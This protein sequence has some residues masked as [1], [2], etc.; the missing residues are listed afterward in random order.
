MGTTDRSG[1]TNGAWHESDRNRTGVDYPAPLRRAQKGDYYRAIFDATAVASIVLSPDGIVQSWNLG[2]EKLFG[3]SED[4]VINRSV[5]FLTAPQHLGLGARNPETG[6]PHDQS[7][8]WNTIKCR[9]DGSLVDVSI[10]A[11]PI[12]DSAGAS[13][14]VVWIVRDISERV[15]VREE[16]LQ[17]ESALRQDALTDPLTGVG[18]R[19]RLQQA[20]DAESNPD[21][22]FVG[23]RTLV[24]ADIDNLKVINDEF[25]HA[26]GDAALLF[27]TRL[28]QSHIRGEDLLARY[29]GDEFIILMPGT[30]QAE[31]A[32]CV[33][34]MRAE[35]EYARI[36]AL[37]ATLT[38]SFG[39]SECCAGESFESQLQR[40]DKAL[41]LAK[42]NGRNQVV[43]LS[44]AKDGHLDATDQS[45]VGART[46]RTRRG[47]L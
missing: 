37:A 3:Y 38:A 27:F 41:Y 30:A 12:R 45:N 15:R 40:I 6:S 18:N 20:L 10:D 19:R 47:D 14:G 42:A 35:L 26:A 5:G 22:E 32:I 29:G 7:Q 25:G 8:H 2:A 4:E 1:T 39:I 13:V 16:Q 24:L 11:S 21:G 43:Q 17:R 34:R 44:A 9:S 33:E 28:I 46:D 31:A 36:P 23:V